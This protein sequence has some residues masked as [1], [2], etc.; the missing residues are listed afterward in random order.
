MLA[1]T[2][3]CS[4]ARSS[5]GAECA[6]RNASAG[7][8]LIELMVVVVI[9]GI[10]AALA[11]YGAR[12]YVLEAKRGEAVGMLTQIRGA[13]EAYRDERF[14]YL[15][16]KDDF[17]MWTPTDTPGGTK[18]GWDSGTNNEMR[19]KFAQLGVQPDGPVEYSYS[20]VAGNIGS[21]TPKI[22]G[23]PTLVVPAATG[24]F[25]IAMGMADLNNDGSYT[26]AIAFSQNNTVE[27]D[28]NY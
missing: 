21:G 28:D 13:E 18:N 11:T 25:Y 24:P 1:T 19:Q 8:T 16:L 27:L 4:R 7:F 5:V 23:S 17:T 20:V 14:D 22:P 15:G 9:M 26:Y 12:K 3:R 2:L 6:R 10:L